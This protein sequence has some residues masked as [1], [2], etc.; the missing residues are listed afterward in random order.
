LFKIWLGAPLLEVEAINDRLDAVDDLLQAPSFTSAFRTAVKKLPDLE[1]RGPRREAFNADVKRHLSRLHA[2]RM[3]ESVFLQVV[4]VSPFANPRDIAEMKGFETIEQSLEKLA[5]MSDSFVTA[6]VGGLLRTAPDLR[7]LL[8]HIQSMYTIKREGQFE[9]RTRG[10]SLTLAE[11]S[12]EILP[13]EGAD[14]VSDEATAEVVRI[15]TA[16]NALLI[17]YKKRYKCVSKTSDDDNTDEL[18]FATSNI[19][20]ARRAEKIFINCKS[21]RAPAIPFRMTGLSKAARRYVLASHRPDLADKQ[22]MYRYYNSE[23]RELVREY[24]EAKETETAAKKGFFGELLKTF[25][26]DRAQWLKAVR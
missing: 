20:I 24:Q 12:I 15:E 7:P 13:T 9:R 5:D 21:R 18:A 17:K 26:Q 1:V 23:V 6:S 4:E 8:R 25:D 11:K 2:G 19:G 10:D 22:K 14:P 16:L 3:K